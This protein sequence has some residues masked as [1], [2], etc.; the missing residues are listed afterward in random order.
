MRRWSVY[1]LASDRADATYVGVTTDVERRLDQHNGL[2]PGGAKSTRAG[3]PWRVARLWGPYESRSHAQRVEY[4]LKRRRG[5]GRLA[6][7][8]WEDV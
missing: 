5:K 1:V 6:D 2:R 8:R 4:L 7:G 3:R